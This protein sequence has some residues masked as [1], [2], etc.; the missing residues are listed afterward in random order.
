VTVGKLAGGTSWAVSEMGG[1]PR[2]N[3]TVGPTGAVLR[4]RSPLLD[5]VNE[6]ARLSLDAFSRTGLR[7]KI[8]GEE[9][10]ARP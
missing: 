5:T 2:G 1:R 6:L 3:V 10:P 8:S 7:R 4:P 9:V